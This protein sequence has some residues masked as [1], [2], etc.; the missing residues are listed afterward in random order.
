MPPT[1]RERDRKQGCAIV[2][3]AIR[4]GIV[5]EFKY[6]ASFREQTPRTQWV[7]HVLAALS[8][9]GRADMS[10]VKNVIRR[11]EDLFD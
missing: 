10:H 8:R 7:L 6:G 5:P 3:R 2:R 11:T 4:H 1:T 9:N